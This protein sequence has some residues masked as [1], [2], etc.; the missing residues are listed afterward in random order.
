[1]NEP[2][3]NEALHPARGKL[4]F[5]IGQ[6]LVVTAIVSVVLMVLVTVVPPLWSLAITSPATK[7][8]FNTLFGPASWGGGTMRWR[9]YVQRAPRMTVWVVGG[10]LL[11][12]RRKLHPQVSH[13]ALIG[14]AGLMLLEV[15]NIGVAVWVSYWLQNQGNTPVGLPRLYLDIVGPFQQFVRPIVEAICW[16]L[17]LAA[18]LGWR[19]EARADGVVK[20]SE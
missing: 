12:R 1:M 20:S 7:E 8:F 2:E 5:S 3:K 16:A 4:R 15:F 14:L 10:M 6:L 19:S 18:V 11:F 9:E 17:I 13:Y